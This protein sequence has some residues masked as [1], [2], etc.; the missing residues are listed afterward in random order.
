MVL[1]GP[2]KLCDLCTMLPSYLLVSAAQ[3]TSKCRGKAID[4]G[5]ASEILGIE[6]F[7]SWPRDLAILTEVFRDFPLPPYGQILGL[8]PYPFQLIVNHSTLCS[9]SL[10]GIDA[11]AL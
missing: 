2:V 6:R 10:Q 4:V 7:K 8:R 9:L 11:E 3:Y 1:M 5:T